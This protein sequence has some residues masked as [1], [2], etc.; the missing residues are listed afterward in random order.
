MG[1]TLALIWTFSLSSINCKN[2]LFMIILSYYLYCNL[3]LY[4]ANELTVQSG[5]N[6]RD[7]SN[8]SVDSARFT[9]STEVITA[10][11]ENAVDGLGVSYSAPEHNDNLHD[12]TLEDHLKSFYT[13][14]LD[15]SD[16]PVGNGGPLSS[17]YIVQSPM[18]KKGNDSIN[19]NVAQAQERDFDI[20]ISGDDCVS[21]YSSSKTS[22]PVPN[23][24]VSPKFVSIEKDAFASALDFPIPDIRESFVGSVGVLVQKD[25]NSADIDYN[26]Q[27]S[28]HRIEHGDT[29]LT[30]ESDLIPDLN[31]NHFA[32]M[33]S[34]HSSHSVSIE[35][36]E[37]S[38]ADA[39]SKKVLY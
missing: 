13:N 7:E 28:G 23:S 15:H 37:D 30:S 38:I 12:S 6:M 34:T 29:F 4:Y 32:S 33:A 11:Q 24:E 27:Q 31:S 19:L 2:I 5:Y 14:N 17:D 1:F 18:R 3:K 10:M 35:S 16:N 25:K 8:G 39:K 21:Q 36:L 26:T 22:A 20:A 9:S